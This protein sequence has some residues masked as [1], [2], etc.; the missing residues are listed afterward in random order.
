MKYCITLNKFLVRLKEFFLKD[1]G[2]NCSFPYERR[3][4]AGDEGQYM[5][6]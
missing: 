5:K 1:F 4:G 6:S 3:L 2:L